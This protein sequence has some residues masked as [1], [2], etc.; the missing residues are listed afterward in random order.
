VF[1]FVLSISSDR[2]SRQHYLICFNEEEEEVNSH[3]VTLRKREVNWQSKAEAL[4]GSACKSRR[5]ISRDPVA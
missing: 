1:L 4:G 5:G 2:F 3:S